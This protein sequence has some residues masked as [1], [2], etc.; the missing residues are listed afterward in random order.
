MRKNMLMILIPLVVLFFAGT[1]FA[2]GQDD[3]F[4]EEYRETMVSR[5]S[6]V[7]LGGT[8]IDNMVIGSTAAIDFIYLDEKLSD[9]ITRSAFVSPWLEEAGRYYGAN[10]GR[11]KTVFIIHIN[12]YETWPVDMTKF[13]VN[14]MNFSDE[15]V[16]TPKEYSPSGAIMHHDD[17]TYFVVG[18]PKKLFK[19]GEKIKVGYDQFE[20]EWTVPKY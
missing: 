13:R 6:T 12:C 15:V 7:Y 20:T 11:G 14:G 17:E 3:E 10:G 2:Q 1:A 18:L 16:L 8:K 4:S 5:T 9:D 19:K